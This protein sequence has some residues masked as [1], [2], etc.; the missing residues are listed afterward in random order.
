M[1]VVVHVLGESDLGV[2]SNERIRAERDGHVLERHLKRRI[3]D[4]GAALDRRDVVEVRQMLLTPAANPS[5]ERHRS[6]PLQVMLREFCPQDRLLLIATDTAENRNGLD[7][8]PL[9]QQLVRALEL[10]PSI[11]DWE[12][13]AR[14]VET[15][16]IGVPT[17]DEGYEKLSGWLSA[18]DLLDGVTEIVTGVGTGATG[19]TFGCLMAGLEAAPTVSV[20]PIQEVEEGRLDTSVSNDPSA[21]L[22]RRRMFGA[23]AA[24]V[25]PV[26]VRTRQLLELLDARQRLDPDRFA[27]LAAATGIPVDGPLALERPQALADAFFDRLTRREVQATMIGRAW[28]L[29]RYTELREDG[30][31]EYRKGTQLGCLIGRVRR[32][33]GSRGDP[34]AA[35]SFLLENELLNAAATDRNHGLRAPKPKYLARVTKHAGYVH[36]QDPRR[37][38]DNLRDLP[39]LPS[40]LDPFIWVPAASGR[41]LVCYCVGRQEVQEGKRP[42]A[43]AIREP[44]WRRQIGTLVDAR[45]DGAA[46]TTLVPVVRLVGSAP[47]SA[48][49]GTIGEAQQSARYLG[50]HL[51]LIPGSADWPDT[52]EVPLNIS[53]ARDL[54]REALLA[55]T[56]TFNSEAVLVLAAPGSNQMNI[57]LL[58]AATD[59]AV[60]IGSPVYLGQMVLTDGGKTGI[61]LAA[62]QVAALPG[63]PH[64]LAEAAREHLADLEVSAAAEVLGRGGRRLAPF[65]AMAEALRRAFVD[66]ERRAVDADLPAEVSR[67]IELIRTVLS[68]A[69]RPALDDW[70]ALHLAMTIADAILPRCPN[71]RENKP[72]S[73]VAYQL[74]S[75]AIVTHGDQVRSFTAALA[76]QPLPRGSVIR[77]CDEL[78]RQVQHELD[79]RS[80]DRGLV[81][82][83]EELRAALDTRFP[84][85]VPVAPAVADPDARPDGPA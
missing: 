37:K 22:A 36:E 28:L 77:T 84:P 5:R 75:Q 34:S 56:G 46:R 51:G 69:D 16:V 11:F 57:G 83:Y 6:M 39:G 12:V 68:P 10:L 70:H 40:D 13:P 26:H 78:L 30:D 55:E 63:Y 48:D 76:N 32:E 82:R 61:R 60:M 49:P 8:A 25:H 42:F 74:R 2:E 53:T 7:T 35:V 79:P 54:I 73:R 29:S 4:L 27:A 45:A 17:L 33:W 41:I 65:A 24:A 31:P 71:W 19:L 52:V 58:L 81:T 50:E 38:E 64:L 85:R 80:P 47:T 23:L 9:A 67:R 18:P 43:D 15:L 3:A 66:V 44:A 21:W 14:A 59:V 20:R 72:F 1:R 62:N